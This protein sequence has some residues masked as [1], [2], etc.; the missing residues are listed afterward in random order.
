MSTT[1]EIEAGRKRS[2]YWAN[3]GANRPQT[4]PDPTGKGSGA[5]PVETGLAPRD[6]QAAAG[7]THQSQGRVPKRTHGSTSSRTGCGPQ[8][9]GG[10]QRSQP[11]HAKARQGDGEQVSRWS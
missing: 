1:D 10:R 11:S 4:K 5:V 3:P 7:R 9:A 8:C 2:E 6:G